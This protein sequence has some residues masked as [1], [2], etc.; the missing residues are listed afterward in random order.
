MP[1][2]GNDDPSI[3]PATRRDDHDPRS[4][5]PAPGERGDPAP[6]VAPASGSPEE[7]E[8]GPPTAVERLQSTQ[9][10][11]RLVAPVRADLLEMARR[12]DAPGASAGEE[13]RARFD[14]VLVELATMDDGD[15]RLPEAGVVVLESGAEIGGAWLERLDRLAG[16][17]AILR[18]RRAPGRVCGDRHGI[19]MAVLGIDA[20]EMP[21]PL[22]ERLGHAAS[23]LRARIAEALR[24]KPAG[25]VSALVRELVGGLGAGLARGGH[26]N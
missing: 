21:D 22:V 3:R 23:D 16:C 14:E 10:F 24:E 8:P 5:D 9:N 17:G 25:E 18:L 26:E 6:P 13:E 4:G 15:V 2:P 12:L 1:K 20:S 7:I 19:A 11:G